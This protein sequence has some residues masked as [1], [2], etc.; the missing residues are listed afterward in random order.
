LEVILTLK[1]ALLS[2]L[3]V[4]VRPQVF[5]VEPRVIVLPVLV[6]SFVAFIGTVHEVPPFHDSS[7]LRELLPAMLLNH[8]SSLT[9]MPSMVEPAGMALKS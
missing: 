3:A 7:T 9:S 8:Q 6:D 1:F 4:Q 2:S 5:V